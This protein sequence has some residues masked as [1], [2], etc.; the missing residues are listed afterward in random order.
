MHVHSKTGNKL[1][2]W[3][4][5]DFFPRFSTVYQQEFKKEIGISVSSHLLDIVCARNHNSH[6]KLQIWN[7]AHPQAAHDLPD[8]HI[9]IS[10]F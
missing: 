2:S 7:Y 5:T 10:A 3:L 8:E 1:P 9:Q 4:G 6:A